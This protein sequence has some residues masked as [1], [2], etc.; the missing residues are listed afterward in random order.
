M[1]VTPR[2]R[3]LLGFALANACIILVAALLWWWRPLPP[4]QIQ[5]VLLPES[6]P[7]QA[8][9]LLDT[10]GN[11]VGR[12]S[13]R[14]QWTLVTYG[15]TT[16]PDVCPATLAELMRFRSRIP[17]IYGEDLDIL[18][19]SV[20]YRR[21][22]PEALRRYLDFFDDRLRGLTASSRHLAGQRAFERSLGILAELEPASPGGLDSGD[23]QVLHGV[24][25]LLLN[26]AGELQAVF[27]P[28]PAGA[29]LPSFDVDT[30]AADYVA[31]RDYL[32]AR[33]GTR[34]SG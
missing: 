14:G 15:F 21:D 16:C 27:E 30:L 22:T 10:A 5:G 3:M 7:L 23:Y 20:D 8:F 28:D 25:L 19:Y 18:F 2:R 4:P 26:P 13:L 6:L 33:S 34:L 24:T 32:S 11:E 17:P 31:L 29:G 12:D 9:T 1:P